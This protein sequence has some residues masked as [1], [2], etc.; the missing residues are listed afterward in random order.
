MQALTVASFAL[1]S[2]LA[3]ACQSMSEGVLAVEGRAIVYNDTS[4]DP[5][6]I[7]SSTSFDEE[8]VDTSG[9][10]G[11]VAFMTPIVDFVGGIDWREFQDEQVTELSLGLRRR[12]L[13]FWRLHPY[14]EANIREGSGLDTGDDE[15][16]YTGWNAGIGAI[17]D[18]T[19]NLF[20]NFRLMYEVTPIDLPNGETDIDGIIGTLGVGFSF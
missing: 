14:I 20:V 13:E 16:D 1:V 17:L 11:Q 4:V 18:V 19:E 9:Y 2:L 3:T 10:G 7:D 8:D 6:D 15:T 5:D 12:V